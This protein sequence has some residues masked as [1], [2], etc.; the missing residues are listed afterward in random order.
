MARSLCSLSCTTLLGIHEEILMRT[1]NME[2][3]ISS[4]A[5][6]NFFFG[7]KLDVPG[8]LPGGDHLLVDSRKRPQTRRIS[9]GRLKEVSL[10]FD[11]HSFCFFAFT[12]PFLYSYQLMERIQKINKLLF[13][14]QT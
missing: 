7:K 12:T 1:I 2:A 9:G 14:F 5:C 4:T 3:H 10:C 8:P 11:F 6:N 13:T